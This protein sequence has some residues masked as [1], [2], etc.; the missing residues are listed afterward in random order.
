MKMIREATASRW[1][2]KRRRIICRW[3]RTATVNSRSTT[4]ACFGPGWAP[5]GVSTRSGPPVVEVPVVGPLA[6]TDPRVEVGVQ[7]VGDQVEPDDGHRGDHQ[8]GQH[9]VGVLRR[10]A[11]DQ[12]LTHAMPC[13]LYT[14]D[15][16]DDLLCVD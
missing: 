14:S 16:A 11:G 9:D 10:D 8:P 13:L 4:P 2:R 6:M 12:Q 1:L 7:H 3:L 5:P 15:A